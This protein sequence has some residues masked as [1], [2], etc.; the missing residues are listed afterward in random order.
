MNELAVEERVQLETE[1][2]QARTTIAVLEEENSVLQALLLTIRERLDGASEQLD[3]L[4]SRIQE[5]PQ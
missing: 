3:E 4:I 2:R 1:L 5:P